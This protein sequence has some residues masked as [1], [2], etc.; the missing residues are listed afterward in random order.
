[1]TA[2]APGA[3]KPIIV[4]ADGA[5]SG[6]PGPAGLGV[7]I[8]YGDRTE[9]LSEFLG[10][11]TNNIAELTAILR[12]S[13]RLK[14]EPRTIDLYT[15]SQYSIGVLTLGWK[16]KANQALIAEIRASLV[17]V[18]CKFHHVRGHS[19]NVGNERVDELARAAVESR[20][21]RDWTVR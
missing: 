2:I 10:H 16:A 17:H 11:G 4:Y 18:R 12:A 7:T 20:R 6:N 8:N 9:E 1:M 21:T 14:G 5:C 3:A 13:V 19:G 15:D